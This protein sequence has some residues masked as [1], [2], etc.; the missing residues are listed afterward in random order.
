MEQHKHLCV[1]SKKKK[2]FRKELRSNILYCNILCD[3]IY[4]VQYNYYS[5]N[6]NS[7]SIASMVY[8]TFFVVE[9]FR[10]FQHGL[11]L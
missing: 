1:N 2:G 7:N 9:V 3:I 4:I 11:F 8:H 6:N 10:Q 5:S